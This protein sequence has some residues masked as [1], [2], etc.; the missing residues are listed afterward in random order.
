MRTTC[1][2]CGSLLFKAFTYDGPRWYCRKAIGKQFRNMY[3]K[4]VMP[5]GDPHTHVRAYT[6]ADLIHLE[7][8][9]PT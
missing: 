2:D 3:G 8:G 7:Q 6:E 4:M 1:P 5:E 9:V